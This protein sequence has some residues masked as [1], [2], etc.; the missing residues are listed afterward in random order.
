MATQRAGEAELT[1]SSRAGIRRRFR[2]VALAVPTAAMLGGALAT[3]LA[4]EAGLLAAAIVLGWTQ[5]A[6]L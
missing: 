4:P 2:M 5:L 3:P 6:G 1:A